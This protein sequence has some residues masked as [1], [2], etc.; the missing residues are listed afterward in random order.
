MGT[1][2]GTFEA[3]GEPA[4]YEQITVSDSVVSLNPPNDASK[5]ILSVESNSLRYRDDGTDPTGSKGFLLKTQGNNPPPFVTLNSKTSVN[6]FKAIRDGTSDATLNVL[7][8]K[9]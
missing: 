1:I 3:R 2:T 8:Y 4:G 5:A 9:T 6:Q 7:Y